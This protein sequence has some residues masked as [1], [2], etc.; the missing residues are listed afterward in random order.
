VKETT[1]EQLMQAIAGGSL[2]AF[3]ELV[4][5]Y[6]SPAWKMAYR[7]LGDAMEAEDV[8]QESLLK[9]LAAASRYRPIA[10]FRTYF[11]R[12][13][14]HLCIDRTRK[15]QLTSIDDIPETIDPSPNPDESL[16]QKERRVRV[17][18][19]LDALPP[20]QL[21]KFNA[22]R[23]R[24][25][26]QL[27]ALG[28]EVKTKQLELIDLLAAKPPH[29]PAIEKKQEEIQRMQGTIQDRVIDHFL[30]ASSFLSPEQQ[31]RFYQ[32]IKGRIETGIQAC[33]PWLRSDGQ[34]QLGEGGRK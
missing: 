5:R 3:N 7:F 13:L 27:Q 26:A 14:T 4:L 33:P 30:Q 31:T 2:D 24:F 16:I 10:T 17:R 19:A 1:D 18:L 25:H 32:L 28:Q 29:Q 11:Y 20:N 12:I 34:G 9:T 21:T 15:Q 6:Q 23:D 8:A 22:E